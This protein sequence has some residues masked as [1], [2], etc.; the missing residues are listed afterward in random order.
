MAALC[1][2]LHL[3]VGHPLRHPTTTTAAATP[4]ISCINRQQVCMAKCSR[5]ALSSQ[6]RRG[7]HRLRADYVPIS[8]HHYHFKANKLKA[9]RTAA[10]SSAYTMGSLINKYF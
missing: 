8:N 5:A 10:M 6:L 2:Y 4:N 9:F 1:G 7:A 3:N